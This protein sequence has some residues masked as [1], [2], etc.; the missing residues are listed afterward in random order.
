MH[1]MALVC[2]KPQWEIPRRVILWWLKKKNCRELVYVHFSSQESKSLNICRSSKQYR[3]NG[4]LLVLS[5]KCLWL[6][7]TSEKIKCLLYYQC[8]V[9]LW[10]CPHGQSSA[11]MWQFRSVWLSDL[12]LCYTSMINGWITKVVEIGAGAMMTS[13]QYHFSLK[14]SLGSLGWAIWGQ[15][16]LACPIFLKLT[17][18][19]C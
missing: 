9:W 2:P 3:T 17:E 6:C 4:G 13:P 7:P 5:C 18:S 14:Y 1:K 19:L 15:G 10:L 8:T 11:H 16:V 12:I